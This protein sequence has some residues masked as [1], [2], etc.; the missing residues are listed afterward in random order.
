M[1]QD[2][3][4][5][6]LTVHGV[7]VQPTWPWSKQYRAVVAESMRRINR[8]DLS[9]EEAERRYIEWYAEKN[10]LTYQQAREKFDGTVEVR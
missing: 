4:D 8:T 7:T 9:P 2:F 1:S 10:G 5:S 6:P 3:S